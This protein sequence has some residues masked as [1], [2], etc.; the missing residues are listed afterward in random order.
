MADS[1]VREIQLSGKQLV[2]VFMAGVVL[3]VVVFLLGVT[4][5]RGAR[6][7]ALPLPVAT[8]T[9]AS[10]EKPQ[11]PP[12]TT[13][14]GSDALSAAGRLTSAANGATS[15]PV[16]TKPLDS[17]PPPPP[18]PATGAAPVAPPMS[19]PAAETKPAATT[20]APV[21]TPPAS[22]A[23][24]TKTPVAA[25]TK[26]PEGSWFVQFAALRSKTGAD[27]MV[28]KLKAEGYDASILD[29]TKPLYRVCVGPF[30]QKSAADAM[31]AK[32]KKEYPS[33]IVTR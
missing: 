15:K 18:P 30:A 33:S 24:V 29:P 25:P 4:V 21:S 16:E 27:T 12:P 22:S 26:A 2:F 31:L 28:A 23:P 5:G 10:V 19:Q 6:G 1:G 8:D 20:K 13:S 3:L 9:T 11:D 14:T 32:V 17:T 7:A